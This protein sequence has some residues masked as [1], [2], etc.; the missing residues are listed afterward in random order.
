MKPVLTYLRRNT[1]LYR[2]G[3][4]PLDAII[5]VCLLCMFIFLFVY[6]V[7][8]LYPELKLFDQILPRSAID[9]RIYTG[10]WGTYHT[11][12]K[13]ISGNF[14]KKGDC[15]ENVSTNGAYENAMKVMNDKHSFGL[16]QQETLSEDDAFRKKLRY[17]TPLYMERMHVFYRRSL[18]DRCGRRVHLSAN[19]DTTILRRLS[20]SVKFVNIGAVGSGTRVLASYILTLIGQQISKELNTYP[21]YQ[22]IDK[23]FKATFD[24]MCGRDP[25]PGRELKPGLRFAPDT[26]ADVVFYVAADPVKQVREVLD[27]ARYGLMSMDPSLVIQLNKEFNLNLSI[28]DFKGKYDSTH[29][30]TTLGTFAYLISSRTVRDDIVLS[31]LNRLEDC[32]DRI[33]GRLLPNAPDSIMPLNE[34]G[35]FNSFKDDYDKSTD[36]HWKEL[37]ALV[38]SLLTLFFP[39][40]KSVT[41]MR[42]IVK[43]WAINKQI[44]RALVILQTAAPQNLRTARFQLF[45]TLAPIRERLVNMYGDGVVPEQL[46]RAIMERINLYM[47]QFPEIISADDQAALHVQK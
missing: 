39:V 24:Q 41:V 28:A 9:Y 7:G 36:F 34:M 32:K 8:L 33:H 2:L 13:E 19:T 10:S 3:R 14:T 1:L 21:K 46:Y 25:K 4:Y 26:V 20:D 11:I 6:Y 47:E 31:L 37:A 43:S 40:F 12:G 5:T 29:H 35:F 44:D 27:S 15:I 22:S 30:L 42:S 45:T 23:R 17:I 16:V 18:F 38:I